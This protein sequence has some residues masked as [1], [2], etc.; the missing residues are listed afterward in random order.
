MT[1]L[2]TMFIMVLPFGEK[3][4]LDCSPSL[5]SSRLVLVGVE[6]IDASEPPSPV[7]EEPK[8]RITAPKREEPAG[9]FFDAGSC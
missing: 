5:F 1:N 7:E 8:L 9:G 2:L 3:I 6:V 4:I